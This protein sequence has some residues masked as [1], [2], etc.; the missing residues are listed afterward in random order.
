[1]RELVAPEAA[2]IT[3]FVDHCKDEK[4]ETTRGEKTENDFGLGVFLSEAIVTKSGR[5]EWNIDSLQSS[6]VVFCLHCPA[7]AYTP[8]IPE[9]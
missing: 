1:M 6:A 3:T 9:H 8:I 7:L 2:F 5:A 4:K